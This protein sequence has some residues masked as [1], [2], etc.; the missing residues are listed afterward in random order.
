MT[1]PRRPQ[2]PAGDST[3]PDDH[4][5]HPLPSLCRA[6]TRSRHP[7]RPKRPNSVWP[8]AQH[9]IH[10][11]A[12]LIEPWLLETIVE[13]VATYTRPGHRVL[14]LAPPTGPGVPTSDSAT[15][16]TRTGD[17][18]LS[19]LIEAAGT[20]SRLGRT[21][22]THTA[23]PHIAAR[24][25]E[26][27]TPAGPQSVHRLSPEPLPAAP[28][29]HG[30]VPRGRGPTAVGPDR[31]DAVIVPV[32]PHF[33]DWIPSV[34]WSGLLAPSGVLA[35]ITHSDRQWGRLIEPGSFV[36]RAARGAGLVPLDRVVLLNIPVRDGALAVEPDL[37][38][39]LSTADAPGAPVPWHT[40]V[41]ADL[42]LFARAR[43]AAHHT[44]KGGR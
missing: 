39:V 16:S 4:R 17:G 18:L 20:A 8:V 37:P 7:R 22:E 36:T 41:H 28:A 44:G 10:P 24:A 19:A 3:P 1:P 43:H 12:R 25:A 33:P 9:R 11:D 15:P 23:D 38:T 14:L 35:F 32:D 29:G 42:L 5:P 6:S 2:P 31:F 21:L 26:D 34:S 40:R 30:P 27:T 13:I